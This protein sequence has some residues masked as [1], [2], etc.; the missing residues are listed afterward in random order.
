MDVARGVF[1]PFTLSPLGIGNVTALSQIIN[2]DT[3][4]LMSGIP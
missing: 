1:L 3:G 2:N 4:M